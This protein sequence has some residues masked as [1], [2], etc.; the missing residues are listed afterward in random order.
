M[1]GHD[2]ANHYSG[3]RL[4]LSNVILFSLNAF[5]IMYYKPELLIIGSQRIIAIKNSEV[6]GRVMK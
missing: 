5:A 4:R 1:A 3:I 2:K 6:G